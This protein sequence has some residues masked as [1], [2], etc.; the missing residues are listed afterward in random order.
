MSHWLYFTV[1]QPHVAWT[2]RYL[3]LTLP[4]LQIT[5]PQ[6]YTT[7]RS[8]SLNLMFPPQNTMSTSASRSLHSTFPPYLTLRQLQVSWT[9]H[10]LNLILRHEPHI[11]STSLKVTW[12]QFHNWNLKLQY[13]TCQP[14]LILSGVLCSASTALDRNDTVASR[15]GF[16]LDH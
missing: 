9:S 8:H 14:H 10:C 15:M 16:D 7:S 1:P 5:L 11:A 13:S 6:P 2:S 3:N 4:Q 12:L